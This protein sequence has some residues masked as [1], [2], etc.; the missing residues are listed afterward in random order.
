MLFKA[1][2]HQSI[3]RILSMSP[4]N[5]IRIEIVFQLIRQKPTCRACTRLRSIKNMKTQWRQRR[6][7]EPYR[8]QSHAI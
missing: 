2:A 1:T 3:H 6:F 8:G 4:R 7:G 5:K